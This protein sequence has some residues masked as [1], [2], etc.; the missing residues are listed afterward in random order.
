MCRLVCRLVF[1]AIVALSFSAAFSSTDC[2]YADENGN[3]PVVFV[4][5]DSPWVAADSALAPISDAHEFAAE[6]AD[7]DAEADLSSVDMEIVFADEETD[8]EEVV[9]AT[10][11][12]DAEL[13]SVNMDFIF[14]EEEAFDE[15]YSDALDD[16]EDMDSVFDDEDD[17]EEEYSDDFDVEDAE[18]DLDFVF[19][20]EDDYEFDDEYSDDFDDEDADSLDLDYVFD[21]EDDYDFDEEDSYDD[22]DDYEF[23]EEYSDDFDDEDADSL[24]L[25]YVFEEE[26]DYDFDEEDS[27][28][29]EDDYEFDEEYSDDFDD[30]D[31]DSFD[32]DYV[33]E[34]EDDY[35]FDEENSYDDEDDYDFDEEYSDDFDDEDA[36]SFDLEY[37]FEEEDEYDFDED[38]SDD[39][40]EEDA[41]SFDLDYVFEE[42][43]TV[44]EELIDPSSELDDAA[45]EEST[46]DVDEF[47]VEVETLE[48]TEVSVEVDARFSVSGVE[49][50]VEEAVAEWKPSYADSSESGGVEDQIWIVMRNGDGF[51][52]QVLDNGAWRVVPVEE[53]Y[54]GD[55]QERTTI[56]WAHG[57]QADLVDVANTAYSLRSTFNFARMATGTNRAYRIVVWKWSSERSRFRIAPDARMKAAIADCEGAS[58]AQFLGG[59]DSSND[60]SLIGFSFGARVVGSALQTAATTSSRYMAPERTG[61][62][63]LVLSSAGCDAGAFDFG[64]YAQGAKIP[65]YVLNVYNPADLALHYYPFI[66]ET[67]SQAQGAMPLF[68]NGFVNASGNT[69]N[70][71]VCASLGRQHSFIEGIQSVPSNMLIDALILAD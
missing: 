27:Y 41:D 63:S 69:Y 15:E 56:V 2:V 21:E 53:F 28:D 62:V 46:V 13:G 65:S 32:L 31:A 67:F 47:V 30:E 1:T 5:E 11:D 6:D 55:S 10:D 44:S 58:L 43:E 19:D 40:D 61:R 17:F 64:A 42:E 34:E 52:C 39:F 20:D 50:G 70:L 38:D 8:S 68:G 57:F 33:F 59:I 51:F 3:A 14:G 25:D 49:Q 45:V 7:V 60:V 16:D 54:A 37:V 48:E 12:A 18:D 24:D 26:D 23:D 35:D 22:E 29:D 9:D 66:S 4:V 36:D 71:N